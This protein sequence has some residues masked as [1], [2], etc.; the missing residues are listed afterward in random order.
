[1]EEIDD[2]YMEGYNRLVVVDK[3]LRLLPGFRSQMH[4]WKDEEDGVAEQDVSETSGSNEDRKE[5]TD[6][7]LAAAMMEHVEHTSHEILANRNREA[8]DISWRVEMEQRSRDEHEEDVSI[9]LSMAHPSSRIYISDDHNV[10][11]RS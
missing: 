8:R 11:R 3:R 9:A 1:M 6:G 2:L 10:Y 4:R 5:G 7:V